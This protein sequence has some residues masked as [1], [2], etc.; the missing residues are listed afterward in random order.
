MGRESLQSLQGRD[1]E[2]VGMGEHI[3]LL[4]ISV[5]SASPKDGVWGAPNGV[6]TLLFPD[7]NYISYK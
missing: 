2:G 7:V 5:C 1:L 4:Y 6:I 3:G